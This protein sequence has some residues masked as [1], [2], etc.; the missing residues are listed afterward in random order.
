MVKNEKQDKRDRGNEGAQKPRKKLPKVKTLRSTSDMKK[1]IGGRSDPGPTE[2]GGSG[3]Q[4][5][6]TC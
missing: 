3:L 6:R 5:G 4:A 1:P 2:R